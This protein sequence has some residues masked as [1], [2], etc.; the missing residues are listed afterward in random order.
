MHLFTCTIVAAVIARNCVQSPAL[1][2]LI[3]RLIPVVLRHGAQHDGETDWMSV[4]LVV[5]FISQENEN[6]PRGFL[7]L[8]SPY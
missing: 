8:D 2:R 3:T 6:K 5:Y 7:L 1:M 4:V